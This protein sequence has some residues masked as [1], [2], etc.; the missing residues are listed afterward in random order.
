MQWSLVRG[1][2]NT[3]VPV[4]QTPNRF[5]EGQI[6]WENLVRDIVVLPWARKSDWVTK[7]QRRKEKRERNC[8]KTQSV[9]H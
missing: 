9:C 2:G 8:G 3:P 1:G 7:Q 4:G 6:I 5:N